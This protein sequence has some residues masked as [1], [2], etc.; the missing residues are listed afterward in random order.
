MKTTL[1][2]ILFSIFPGIIIVLLPT[3]DGLN[4]TGHHLLAFTVSIILL[5]LTEP[6][7]IGITALLVGAGLILFKIQTPTSAW[8]PY[9]SPS[10]IFVMMII[11]LG[12]I[13]NEVGITNRIISGILKLGG[14]KIVRFSI[15]LALGSSI[16]SSILHD[17]AV[18]II[19]IYSL[20]PLF[21][22][23]NITPQSSNNFSKFLTILIPLSA[24][25]GGFGTIIG[26][27]RNP[28]ALD[29]LK[30]FDGTDIGFFEYILYQFPLVIF[31]SLTT[32]LICFLTLK[33]NIYELPLK[34]EKST[35][36]PL[37]KKEKSLLI[38]IFIAFVFWFIGDLT[39]I[40]ITIV[41]TLLIATICGLGLVDL[42]VIIKKFPWDAWLV[43]GAGVSLGIASIDSGLGKWISNQFVGLLVD[44]PTPIKLIAIGIFASFI[45]SFTSNTAA[46]A[47]V[48]PIV[49]PLASEIGL[50]PKIIALLIPASTS[51][52]WFVV[53]SP[54][55]LFAYSTGYFSQ[56]DFSKVAI[57]CGIGSILI[58]SLIASIYWSLV[59]T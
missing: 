57:S 21:S 2:K 5:W 42:K 29:F 4:N 24:S 26:G 7:P 45:S 51:F 10:V 25:A 53:G 31:V 38:L 3:P 34:P 15:I 23:L 16:L 19:F 59:L 33:P 44:L 36:N 55:S 32:W 49:L 28:V 27:G 37:S 14:R 6:I 52:V 39:N 20:F 17:A 40:H 9:A 1:I 18:T 35:P 22:K 46:T 8:Q 11:M 58:Y 47:I 12:I 56:T 13:I 43:F 54:P 50:N 41:A 48:L 30:N